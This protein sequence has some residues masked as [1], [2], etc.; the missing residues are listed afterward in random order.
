M[1]AV[2]LDDLY[3]LHT[4]MRSEIKFMLKKCYHVLIVDI[5]IKKNF[6]NTVMNLNSSPWKIVVRLTAS[7]CLRQLVPHK[8][9]VIGISTFCYSNIIQLNCITV[10][11]GIDL[12]TIIGVVM[13]IVLINNPKD[14][15]YKVESSSN[16]ICNLN[17]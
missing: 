4:V 7:H 10:C 12:K 1:R 5:A 16:L 17:Q 3:L 6:G 8:L 15:L 14:T 9:M 13:R 2:V 11:I